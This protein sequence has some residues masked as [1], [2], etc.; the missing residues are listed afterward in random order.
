MPITHSLR[1]T[2]TITIG[3][4]NIKV[5]MGVGIL[6]SKYL[7]VHLKK[8]MNVFIN[9]RP[10]RLYRVLKFLNIEFINIYPETVNLRVLYN[11]KESERIK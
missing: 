6:N 5:L 4:Y 1:Y 9:E 2:N 8:N 10:R 11:V 7:H 3:R